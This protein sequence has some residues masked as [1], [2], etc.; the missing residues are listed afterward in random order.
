VSSEDD[1]YVH[2]PGAARN[3]DESADGTH[4][5]DSAG[6]EGAHVEGHATAA[7]DEVDDAGRGGAESAGSVA[8]AH[9]SD[10][11]RDVGARGWVLIGVLGFCLIGA[12]SLI[13][14]R[15]P[16]LPYWVAFLALPMLPAVLLGIVGVWATTRP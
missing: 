6:V 8:G 16:V 12:P 15:P 2:R 5:D 14:W 13:L 11:D 9:P 10:V 1:G 3:D 7:S 4:A